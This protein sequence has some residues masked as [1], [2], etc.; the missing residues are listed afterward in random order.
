MNANAEPASGTPRVVTSR[1]QL[2]EALAGASQP[3]A[4][5]MT[6]GGLHSG[7][8]ALMELGRALVG[9]QGHLTATIFVNPLQF[10]ANEDLAKY[11][12]TFDDDL[13]LCAANS[14]DLVF[15][16]TPDVMYPNGD[17]EV[18]VDPGEL[19]GQYEGVARPTHF[20]GVLTVVMK[21]LQL[22]HPTYAIFGEKDYQQL[23]LIRQMVRDLDIPVEI[24]AGPTVRE[25]SG[26]AM[27]TRNKYLSEAA[28]ETALRIPSAIAAGQSVS[29]RGA[30]AVVNVARSIL[31]APADVEVDVQYVVVTDPLMGP[32]PAAGEGRL[33]ITA[34]VDGT[35]LLDNA[36]VF[37][38]PPEPGAADADATSGVDTTE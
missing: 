26:L 19:G 28:R 22:T 29:E 11:P 13:A 37:I 31:E 18:T 21:L 2:Q 16:P 4:V 38:G 8:G 7:H 36:Q 9:P 14:V 24:V 33:I 32:A 3:S 20:S 1:S 10:G 17:P 23:T 30:D 34:I 6:M 35:R 15:A 12:R 5:V 25:A 27:S